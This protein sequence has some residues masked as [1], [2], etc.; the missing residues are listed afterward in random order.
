MKILYVLPKSIEQV[1]GVENCVKNISLILAKKN[2]KIDILCTGWKI[3]KIKIKKFSKNIRIIEVK[4]IL[5]KNSF[6]LSP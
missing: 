4:R 3:K 2:Y 1:G 5:F 6:Y